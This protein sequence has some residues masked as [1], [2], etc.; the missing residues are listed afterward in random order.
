VEKIHYEKQPLK[1]RTHG[2]EVKWIFSPN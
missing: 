1:T 2:R